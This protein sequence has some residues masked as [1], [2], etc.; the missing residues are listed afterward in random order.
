MRKAY[1]QPFLLF[2]HREFY[3]TIAFFPAPSS[4][5]S[6]LNEQKTHLCIQKLHAKM[7]LFST[8]IILDFGYIFVGKGFVFKVN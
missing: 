8:R 7:Y 4:L 3:T 5:E 1:K 2:P 6:N